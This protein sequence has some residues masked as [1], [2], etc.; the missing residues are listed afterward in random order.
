MPLG[1][2]DHVVVI[3]AGF[4][5]WRFVEALRRDGFTGAITLIGDESDPPY[6]R[7][8]LTKQVLVGK[9]PP[10]HAT[11]ATPDAIDRAGVELLLGRRAT[12]LDLSSSLVWLEDGSTVPGTYFV[13]ATGVRARRLEFSATNDL[14][15]VRSLVDIRR[16]LA[17]LDGLASGELVAIIGGGFI[18]AEAATQLQRRGLRPVVLESAPRPLLGNLGPEVSQWLLGLASAD[19]VELRC[20]VRIGDVS[21]ADDG[22][23]VA[24]EDGTEL[25]A[26]LVIEAVGAVAN[27]EWLESSGLVVDN[28]VV[29]DDRLLATD[30]V[31]A[32]GDVA[33]FT[34][35]NGVE[36]DVVRIEHWQVANDHAAALAHHWTH[37]EPDEL[38]MIPY[39]WSDQYGKKIQV[40]GHPRPSDDVR[41]V[42]GS[43]DE[44]RWMALY[45]RHGVV[46]GVIALS[47]PRA[48][49]LAK[50]LLDSAT[51]LDA[52]IT[53]AP[54]T[55]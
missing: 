13:I 46:T 30:R 11:L 36:D 1:N 53:A 20:D 26:G 42:E 39:F 5:G 55:A 50:P 27:T 44:G 17:S 47:H 43:V 4:A 51:T 33:R 14:H 7:P 15:R 37:A 25:R 34:W 49:M 9:W 6:D 41:L 2:D 19:G 18:G 35:R 40:L 10:E 31:G 24:F 12:G 32:I 21:V 16:L 3:G 45:S 54:W 48:L 38:R 52:A 22:F 29:V 28:G 8:P 23:T